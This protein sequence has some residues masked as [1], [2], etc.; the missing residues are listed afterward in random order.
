MWQEGGVRRQV[1]TCKENIFQFIFCR[2]FGAEK[3]TLIF[4][5]F[6]SQIFS[7]P[8]ILLYN[9]CPPSAQVVLL[10]RCCGMRSPV[11]GQFVFIVC[12]FMGQ[13]GGYRLQFTSLFI[14]TTAQL[15]R[16]GGNFRP[17]QLWYPFIIVIYRSRL[18]LYVYIPPLNCLKAV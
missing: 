3:S 17:Q 10:E 6:Q 15:S 1:A 7:I 14:P 8:I 16:L 11:I 2:K 4:D 13:V 18:L 12:Y 5:P 9:F